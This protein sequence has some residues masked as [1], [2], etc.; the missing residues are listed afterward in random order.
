MRNFVL[1]FLTFLL[2]FSLSSLSFAADRNEDAAPAPFSSRIQPDGS[3]AV[4]LFEDFEGGVVPAGWDSTHHHPDSPGFQV[5]VARPTTTGNS[6]NVVYVDD[7][8]LGSGATTLDTLYSPSI[9][10]SALTTVKLDFWH[11]YNWISSDSTAIFVI[12]NDV[13]WYK[14]VSYH[15]DA[16]GDE[17]Y[18]ISAYAAGQSNVKLAFIYDDGGAYAWYWMIDNVKVYEP[19]P[20]NY[21]V[22]GWVDFY[23]GMLQGDT[24]TFS[25][26]V[27]NVGTAAQTDVPVRFFEDGVQVGSDVLVSLAPGE[28]DTVYFDYTPTVAGDHILKVQSFL[29]GDTD[30]TNDYV[31]GTVTVIGLQNIPFADNFESSA[32]LGNYVLE[33]TGTSG[34]IFI[35]DASE[36]T[37]GPYSGDSALVSLGST[38][39]GENM[40]TLYLNLSGYTNVRLSFAWGIYSLESG[41]YMVLDFYDG[42][43]HTG[44]DSLYDWGSGSEQVWFSKEFDLSSYN[45][46]DGFAIRFR[47]KHNS[48][49]D[50]CFIDML[51]VEEVMADDYAVNRFIDLQT[52]F[53]SGVLDT[54][55]VEVQN[56]GSN[57]QTDVPVRLFEDGVQVGTDILVSLAPG[58][59][60]TISFDYTPS[61][62]GWKELKA[63]AFLSG[64]QNPANDAI[65]DSVYVWEIP[66]VPI[67]WTET[68]PTTTFDPTAWVPAQFNGIP[69]IIDVNGVA[70][71]TFP[72]ALPSDPYMLSVSGETSANGNYDQV[73]TGKFDLSG[74]SNYQFYFWKSENDLELGEYVL[75]EYY[76]NDGT[77]HL[78]DS[79][80]G[81]DNG[82]GV[83]EPFHP[84]S[85][86][87]PA[88]AYHSD[89]R[90]RFT[91]ASGMSY[92]DEYYFD[93]LKLLPAINWCNLQWPPSTTITPGVPTENIYGQIWIEGVTPDPGAPIVAELGYGPHGSFP[94]D[95]TTGL[96]NP[97]WTWVPAAYNTS[98]TGNNNEYMAQLTINDMGLYDYAYRYSYMDGPWEYADLDG[99][100]VL[101]N[102]YDP[103]QAGNLTVAP[104]QP[105]VISEIMYNP[106]DNL[107][108]SDTNYE[109][110][111]L[112]N[113]GIDTV[114]ISGWQFIYGF[115][116]TF[117]AGSKIPPGEYLVV[118]R[119]PASIGLFYGITNI[120]GPFAG[121]ALSNSGEMVILADANG[122]PV[123]TVDYDDW[124]PWPIDG[125]GYGTSIEVVDLFGDNN[126]PANWNA[127]LNL[128][129]TPGTANQVPGAPIPATIYM[130]QYTPDPSG[131]SPLQ[132]FMV[133]VTGTVTEDYFVDGGI[134]IQ[135]SASTW[136]GIQVLT[137][138]HLPIGTLVS[139]DGW[140]VEWYD[141]TVLVGTQVTDLGAGTLPT[142]LVVTPGM[143][144]TGA[145]TAEAYECV[146]IEVDNV[147]V[148]NDNA[149]Y[150]EWEVTDG[151]DV[152]LVDN[153]DYTYTPTLGDSLETLKGVLNY[154]FSDFKIAPRSDDDFVFPVY[155]L[156]ED[157]S[158][159]A[160][161]AG[162]TIVDSVGNGEVWRFDNPGGRVINTT[163]AA[164]GFAIFDSDW[165][166]SG[167]GPENCDLIS[168]VIDCSAFSQ[169]LFS[170]EHYFQAGF[171]GAAEVFVSND[172]GATWISLAS[173]SATSTGNADK[174]VFDISAYA[175]GQ[176]QVM[177][178]FN[179]TG[180]YSWYWAVDD[181]IISGPGT[182][183]GTVTVAS[184]G[185]PLEN[186]MVIA[187]ADTAYTDAS[188]NYTLTV[189]GGIYD[190]TVEKTGYNPQTAEFVVVIPGRTRTLDFAMT[191]PTID[192]DV[193]SIDTSLQIGDFVE[194]PITISNNGNGPLNYSLTVAP[195]VEKQQTD[196]S[197]YTASGTLSSLKKIKPTKKSSQF[198]IENIADTDTVVIHFDGPYSNNGIGTNGLASW[199]C[200]ARFTADELLPYYGEY[201]ITGVQIHIR[202]ASFSNVTVKI[203]QGGSFGDPGA[204]IYSQD[205]TGQ[206]I[207]GDWTYHTLT[208][209]IPLL[210][211]NEYWIGYAIDATGD[212]PSSVDAGPA[213]PGKGDWMYFD[214]IWQEISTAFGLDYNWNIRGVITSDAGYWLSVAPVS[215]TIAA[216]QQEVVT[217]K[218]DA[219]VFANDTTVSANIN[220]TSDPDVG[221]PVV[222]VNLTVLPLGYTLNGTVGLSDFPTD[223]SGTRIELVQG[224]NTWV[225]STDING[226]YEFSAVL[227]GTY[228]LHFIHTGYHQ[229]DTTL[230]IS[231]NT[232][233]DVML[234]KIVSPPSGVTATQVGFTEVVE[235]N[236][237]APGSK[238][239]YGLARG[240]EEHNWL[241]SLDGMRDILLGYNVYR[242]DVGLLNTSGLVTDT[243]YVDTTVVFDSTY[244][245]YVTAV[246]DPEGES[247]PS[248]TAM[249]TVHTTPGEILL[250]D[251][252]GSNGGSYED[253]SPVYIAALNQLNAMY[254]TTY[255][256]FEVPYG[257]DGPDAG[258]LG[259]YHTVIWFTGETWNSTFD[260]TLTATD[261]A[262]LALYLSNG[263]NLFLVAQDY[264]WDV[265][266]SAGAFSAGQFP[267]DFLGV[268][269]TSQDAW[270]T[271]GPL[272]ATGVTGSF[273]E[274][275]TFTVNTPFIT[276]GTYLYVDDVVTS[277]GN[278]LFSHT[279]PTGNSGVYYDGGTF[280][281]VFTTL[282][283][284]GMQDGTTPS[285]K[286]EFLYRVLNFLGVPSGIGQAQ[287]GI[288][289][290]FDLKPNYPN[291]FNPSTT[292]KYQLPKAVDV[293]L[294]IYNILGQRVKTLVNKKA[295]PGY[296]EVVWDGTNDFGQKVASGLYI[297]RIK[298]GDYVKSYKMI[299]MK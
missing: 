299:L 53:Q 155:I 254:G 264:L 176:S 287:F 207:V 62:V 40:W 293:Q 190:V 210:S 9:D 245:Y 90:L 248:D 180:D 83:F 224:A 276:N 79:L 66:T 123:D 252:D 243:F 142:P 209:P 17:S 18:D 200:A 153:G 121:G 198:Q 179:W 20:N 164:N 156:Y 63:Q 30:P 285:T 282:E 14:V 133:Q 277:A 115:D 45:L 228:D 168:P 205:I 162:W 172:N 235:V 249:V 275:M 109:Y 230:T 93:D 120:V 143:V 44:I 102:G 21:A 202:D 240:Q 292:I 8:A 101:G 73:V 3:R 29:S 74:V 181:V 2:I 103:A 1:A 212:H 145:P 104:T 67:P 32:S 194:V 177:V 138:N 126:D 4:L 131:T 31:E 97:D 26:E 65:T 110:V 297:Y 268:T 159:G 84:A 218:L 244:Y 28:V 88:D 99:A 263:G 221:S 260:P 34:D 236:W 204:E 241:Y 184:S 229:F 281:T 35:D 253:I 255:D 50:K 296:Y 149:G 195:V 291:P 19:D 114:D 166:G 33:P 98:Y 237:M 94:Y 58:E 197:K 113:V 158:D 46:I 265:Y 279:G 61:T 295:E 246:Y 271:A 85:Y 106:N 60:D 196:Y 48:T 225:D 269:S 38:S 154:S 64:D 116:Y 82:Y 41:E 91:A 161:P 75:I 119:D 206:V 290:V 108:G 71:G 51:K 16:S 150:G 167:G 125:D 92:T 251:D 231:A 118:A 69:E 77:W 216:G 39:G 100:G 107:Q 220:F 284:A 242:T 54:V 187:G 6:T 267:Y 111:E 238:F 96:P 286:V 57:A 152:L 259:L 173:W 217:A 223:L 147:T 24:R 95:T 266:P 227:P 148:S 213:V 139:V 80:A 141:R 169:V 257:G 272:T 140:V 134:V 258:T 222:P 124:E 183:A 27:A 178:K 270:A 215:G 56:M 175:A 203:W 165:Y 193:T 112:A 278:Y 135:D 129:G 256:Y 289:K 160:L 182:I 136:N 137:R 211:G 219:S 49:V 234:M 36:M 128:F 171:G 70:T 37:G 10:C 78:L 122:V 288:P 47:T 294:E 55:N 298:A 192:L 283:F 43:W 201:G 151:V 189:P 76:A 86:L 11:Y 214:G 132:G 72:Y 188:G 146:L 87:L 23:A 185:S 170:F 274:G 12:V 13:D 233:L 127:S 280:R 144:N 105:V 42:T 89:F 22:T 232:T 157:F 163:T 250:V 262:N 226:Y 130:V 52:Y 273:T 68:F 208:T 15:A 186:A 199:I 81:T 5:G 191:A 117:P 25:A 247:D 239:F 7:D 174:E 261:E 59:K